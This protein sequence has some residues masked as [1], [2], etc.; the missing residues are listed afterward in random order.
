MRTRYRILQTKFSLRAQTLPRSTL[1]V[2][3]VPHILIS[4]NEARWPA[5]RRN[6]IWKSVQQLMSRPNS[7][8]K[9]LKEAIRAHMQAEIDKLVRHPAKYITI[10]R[11]LRQPVWDPTLLLPCTK[12]ERHRLVKWR[13]AWLPPTPSVPCQCGSPKANRDHLT[14]C[15]LLSSEFRSFRWS[16]SSLTPDP[17]TNADAIDVALNLLPRKVTAKLGK[18]HRL[19]PALLSLLRRIDEITSDTPFDDEPPAGS[20]LLEASQSL[21][22]PPSSSSSSPT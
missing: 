12:K 7:P 16:L 3:V 20:L 17:P 19:W 14:S 22:S 15:P 11:G 8:R 5:L 21:D 6:V 13:L 18:W 4:Q 10:K 1:V 9:P 2:C